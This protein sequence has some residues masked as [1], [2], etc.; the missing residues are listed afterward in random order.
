M[1]A[2]NPCIN[3]Y[4]EDNYQAKTYFAQLDADVDEFHEIEDIANNAWEDFYSI[5]MQVENFKYYK[6]GERE[7]VEDLSCNF[8]GCGIILAS[9]EHSQVVVADDSDYYHIGFGLIPNFNYEDLEEEVEFELGDAQEVLQEFWEEPLDSEHELQLVEDAITIIKTDGKGHDTA[10]IIIVEFLEEFTLYSQLDD[11]DKEHVTN[12]IIKYDNYDSWIAEEMD[13]KYREKLQLFKKDEL[14]FW[15]EVKRITDCWEDWLSERAGAWLSG[16]VDL[17]D[18]VAEL[19][20]PFLT[21]LKELKELPELEYKNS[22]YYKE[23]GQDYEN[24]WVEFTHKK[25]YSIKLTQTSQE[26]KVGNIW[27]TVSNELEAGTKDISNM[28]KSGVISHGTIGKD[29]SESLEVIV[30]IR[31]RDCNLCEVC[32]HR[33]SGYN[34]NYTKFSYDCKKGKYKGLDNIKIKNYCDEFEPSIKN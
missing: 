26:G 24:T 6:E 22:N 17:K 13:K 14:H 23:E 11:E 27:V 20:F 32:E 2:G 1:G 25:W 31:D 7:A 19:S 12:M 3:S 15:K 16:K 21:H 33:Y 29:I 8:R 9:S 18:L 34:E 10:K 28:P 30:S 4:D 5:I